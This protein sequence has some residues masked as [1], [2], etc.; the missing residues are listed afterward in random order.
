[1]KRILAFAFA[2]LLFIWQ[3]VF[4]VPAYPGIIN[5]KQPDGSEININLLG[6]EWVNWA[7]SLDG[8][9]MLF[10][11]DGFLEYA[12][13]DQFGD[14]KLSGIRARNV[15][16][17]TLEEQNFLSRQPKGLKHSSSQIEIKRQFSR[18]KKNVMR[19]APAKSLQRAPEN[20]RIPIIL[21]EFQDK[22]FTLTKNDFEDLLNGRLIDYFSDNSYGKFN[23]QVDIFGP[24]QLDN[25]ISHYDDGSNGDPGLMAKEAVSL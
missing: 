13:H 25:N 10:N 16:E 5:Y 19:K 23:L 22:E 9:T 20:V 12:V 24:Y 4:A 7:V 3:Q 8:Y 11:K 17:R 14:L 15:P 2:T 21:V 1:M 6:D 18:I